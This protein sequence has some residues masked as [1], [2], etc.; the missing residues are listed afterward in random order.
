MPCEIAILLL[1]VFSFFVLFAFW[2]TEPIAYI[3][4]YFNAKIILPYYKRKID[5]DLYCY[6]RKFKFLKYTPFDFSPANKTL[7]GILGRNTSLYTYSHSFVSESKG[8][9][10]EI[11]RIQKAL[12]VF[13][14]VLFRLEN[15]QDYKKLISYY[16]QG[17]TDEVF[18]EKEA[19]KEILEN[20]LKF[21]K[22]I[23]KNENLNSVDT[24]LYFN[25]KNL[26]ELVKKNID[27]IN[28][29]LIND[30]VG[31]KLCED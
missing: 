4:Y 15:S 18:V 26:S 11:S 17:K 23:K 29:S 12:K 28:N 14:Y 31:F 9:F 6:V 24:A 10:E 7:M 22:T 2:L 30:I 27:E 8:S 1:L 19:T 20:V 16:K 5:K 21:I 25:G 3:A 13:E